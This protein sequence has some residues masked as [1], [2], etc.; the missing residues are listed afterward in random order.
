MRLPC[1]FRQS[2]SGPSTSRPRGC[3]V[4]SC[5]QTHGRFPPPVDQLQESAQLSARPHGVLALQVAVLSQGSQPVC[6]STVLLTISVPSALRG[7][8]HNQCNEDQFL[9]LGLSLKPS[10]RGLE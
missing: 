5:W 10:H 6:S 4:L 7:I 1:S 3:T 8:L 2:L 9:H